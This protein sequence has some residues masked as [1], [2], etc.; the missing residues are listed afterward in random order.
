MREK[1][2]VHSVEINPRRY[3]NVSLHVG[4]ASGI[5]KTKMVAHGKKRLE[6]LFAHFQTSFTPERSVLLCAH[7]DIEPLAHTFEHPFTTL[8][9]GHWGALDGKNEW[10]DFD[11]VVLFGLPYRDQVWSN[12]MFFA[13]QGL[14]GDE[15]M[16]NPSWGPYEDVR[17]VMET[18]QLSASVIQAVNRIRCRRVIDKQGNCPAADVFILL[19][20]GT[21]GDQIL[22]NIRTEMPGIRVEDWAFELDAPAEGK[23]R[24]GSSHDAGLAF[25]RQQPSGDVPL[26]AVKDALQI[27]PDA[28][29]KLQKAL[30]D[31]GHPLTK[32]LAEIGVAYRLLTRSR[33]G[34]DER[35]RQAV[36]LRP[37][38]PASSPRSP[39][40]GACT[41]TASE[42]PCDRRSG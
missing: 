8:K 22:D 40:S 19:P 35:S 14:P 4:R 42:G 2:V 39:A 3:D 9:V 28:L 16:A 31:P 20:N 21:V 17:R 5:G 26:K 25:M 37:P 29:K 23:V 27:K 10:Q 30:R 38:A 7:K 33:T 15:W 12:G 24:S 34:F 18:K 6:R 1:A 13:L 41:G 36:R 32:E 11:T